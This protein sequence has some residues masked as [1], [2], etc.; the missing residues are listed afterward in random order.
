MNLPTG[1]STPDGPPAVA[2]RAVEQLP[3]ALDFENLKTGACWRGVY[4][5]GDQLPEVTFG[6]VFK[7]MN[8]AVMNDVTIRSFR[9]N[10]NL[11]ARA[12]DSIKR[13]KS[14]MLLN[15]IESVE[16]E[17]RRIEV[18]Q[19]APT[20]TLREW[21]GRR[22]ANLGEIEL[23]VRQLSE[24]LGSLHSQGVV[25][26]N[27]RADTIFVRSSEGG[28]NVLL[29]GFETATL[30]RADC[31]VEVSI[32]PFSAPP[33]AVG[34]YHF[35]REPGLRAWDWWSLGRV[36]QEVILGR[37][38]L[39]H[40]LERDVTRET[41]ELRTR[42]ENL[43]KEQDIT[44]RAG[45][46]EMMPVMD[47][48]L[49]TL[50]RGLL[51][52]SREGRWGLIEVESWLRKEPVKDRYNLPRNE[53]LFIWKERAYTVPE[54]AD[55]FASAEHWKEGVMN[56][57]EPLNTA[58]LAYFLE[59]EKIH[60]K[61]KERFDILIKLGESTVM[62]ELPP[63][64]VR[65]VVMAVALKFL[66]G[67]D[68]PLRLR[69]HRI[70][71]KCLR[72]LLLPEAQPG[73]LNTV[74]AFTARPVVQQIE[75]FDAELGNMLGSLDRIYEAALALAL[76]NR[77]LENTDVEGKA[78]LMHLCLEIESD[79][80]AT[81]TEMAKLYACS[82]DRTLDKLFKKRDASYAELA[83]IAYTGRDPRK[84]SYVTHQEWNVEQ[85]RVLSER[86]SQLAVA[87]LW[88]RLGHAI[89][90]GLP[91][92]GR[93]RLMLPLWTVLA[94]TVAFI[95]QNRIAYVIA[96][97]CPIAALG[98]RILWCGF[99]RVKLQQRLQLKRPWTLRSG[100]LRCHTEALMALKT[101]FAPGPRALIRLLHETNEE[102]SRLTLDPPAKAIPL[103]PRFRDT[104][105][106][107]LAS[108]LF[109]VLLSGG[110]V[111]YAIKHPPKFPT[112][113]WE[114]VKRLWTSSEEDPSATKEEKAAPKLSVEQTSV[115]AVKSIQATLEELR[116]AKKKSAEQE[117][118]EIKISWPF[119]TP[120]EALV[121]RIHESATALPEQI[122]VAEEMAQLLVDRYDP[123]TIN[124]TIAVQVPVA[125]EV[126]LMLYDGRTGKISDR[127]VYTIGYV[128]FARSWLELD[129]QKA[130]FLGG[131]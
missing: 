130:I 3:G 104:Q 102:I 48:N 47:S 131:L 124:A 66:A 116:R 101:D 98:L 38:I 77:W 79:L 30:L 89:K 45:A 4:Q 19:A 34:L 23:I 70:D 44:T 125:K 103:P 1:S 20:L 100:W 31:P 6:R 90:L 11:R 36:I 8:V 68:M 67:H 24:A 87:A 110:T 75:Q 81:R 43:L 92:F 18:T 29:G 58:T 13:T 105:I 46:V 12:W 121:V 86:G 33:E 71:I 95:G 123:K 112:A 97:V 69:G 83:V 39:G 126:G 74:R 40:I 106:V 55:F 32:D 111:G 117:V 57:F 16:G 53:H 5:I 128:P 52:G 72:L 65:T 78:V 14:G 59:T 54:A 63:E 64:I 96:A 88:L 76:E 107:A 108:W 41:P 113:E 49:T 118:P 85:H 22:K 26:L 35:T 42:A 109:V 25:H 27:V 93:L 2:G 50:L 99:H 119:K 115:G 17:G 91:V 129:S 62:Q 120:M 127:K 84:F 15:L 60:K 122:A 51:T 114:R 28:L 7:A 37:H 56:V 9:V 21:A 94:T 80:S 61:T 82:R 10:D 73:G